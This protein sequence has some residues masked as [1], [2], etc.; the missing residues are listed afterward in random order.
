MAVSISSAL[1][2]LLSYTACH[3]SATQQRGISLQDRIS[4]M[5][6][7]M[8]NENLLLEPLIPCGS[9]GPANSGEQTAAE[10]VRIV[11]HDFVTANVIAGTGCVFSLF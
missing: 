2:L 3:V 10:W 4:N 11:F 6:E 9:A 5:E 8:F 7:L 1:L